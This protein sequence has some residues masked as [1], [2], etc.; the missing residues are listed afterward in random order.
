MEYLVFIYGWRWGWALCSRDALTKHCL[1]G[2]ARVILLAGHSI[3][4]SLCLSVALI[5]TPP[6]QPAALAF[7]AYGFVLVRARVGR[8]AHMTKPVFRKREIRRKAWRAA[9]FSRTCWNAAASAISVA[10]YYCTARDMAVGVCVQAHLP[11]SLPPLVPG[12]ESC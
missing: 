4:F 8:R 5:D 3:A 2:T 1:R 10:M 12:L 6:L 11:Y 9:A 7:V